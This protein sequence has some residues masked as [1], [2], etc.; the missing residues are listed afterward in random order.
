MADDESKVTIV[1][2]PKE[3]AVLEHHFPSGEPC[4]V[5]ISFTETPAQVI[6]STDPAQPVAVDMD[7]KVTAREPIPICIKLCEPI[8]ARS[9][10]TIGVSIFDNPVASISIRG[11]TRIHNCREQPVSERVCVGFDQIKAGTTFASA[12]THE[13]LTFGPLGGELRAATFGEPAGRTKLAFMNAGVRVDFPQPVEDVLLTINDYAHP[14]LTI[15]AYA[16]PNLLTQFTVSIANTVKEVTLSQTGIT[17]LT[18]TGGNNEA[19]LVEVC[20]RLVQGAAVLR[21]AG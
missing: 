14:D 13:G 15:S 11:M 8:C 4:P 19:A 9:D 1:A 6:V 3:A 18:V 2:W 17:A 12:F 16:G 20:Y 5:S 21:T 10:Y 7:M